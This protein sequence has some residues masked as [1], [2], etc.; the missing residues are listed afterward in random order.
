M[1]MIKARPTADWARDR[2]AEVDVELKELKAAAKAESDRFAETVNAQVTTSKE[3][4]R[5][6][7]AHQQ[8][9]ERSWWDRLFDMIRDW[10]KQASANNEAWEKQRNAESRDAMIADFNVL[11]QMKE[12]QAKGNSEAVNSQF[13]KLSA[14]QKRLASQYFSGGISGIDFVAQSTIGRIGERRVTE[15]TK[16]LE[17]QAIRVWEWN[18]LG[19]LAKATN[20][21]FDPKGL[22]AKVK[23]AVAGWG[24][25]E[26]QV[27]AALGGARTAIERA[28][29]AKAYQHM[30]GVSMEADIKDDM[31]GREMQRAKALMEGK[32]SEA[33]AAAIR[34][35]VEG[36]GTDEAAIKNALRGKSKEELKEIKAE[37][38]RMYKVDLTVDL[39]DDMEDAELDNALALADGDLDKA[40]A[41][42]LSDA[43]DGP[44]TD[45]E[46]LKKVYER[47]REE[48][49]AK[50]KSE[51]LTPGELKQRIQDR[52]AKVK[53]QFN[54]K[55]GNLDA[56]MRDELTDWDWKA[57]YGLKGLS[58]L[59]KPV[60]DADLKIV[61]AMQSGDVAR[62]D[63]A[64]AAKEHAGVYTS[65]DEIENVVRNQ[66]KQAELDVGLDLAA[67]RARIEALA[68]S[69]D[70]TEDDKKKQ[71]AD[72]ETESKNRE[73][74]VSAKAKENLGKLSTAYGEATNGSQTFDQLVKDETSGYSKDE[75][76]DLIAAGGKLSDEEE[77]YYATAG[78]GT[79]EDKIKE[80][81]KGKSKDE[82]DK[83]RKA[84]ADKHPGHTLD[85]DLLGDLSGREDLDVGHTLQ[86][87]D[88]ETFARQLEEAKTPEDRKK[89]IAGMKKMLDDRQKFEQTGTIGQ[90]FALGADPMNSA[91]QLKEAV[92]K[93]EAYDKALDA[94]KAAH[95]DAKPEDLAND[96]A[97]T[98]AKANFDMNYSGALESQEQVREQIDAYADVAVQVG[99]AV[100]ALAITIATAGTAGPVMAALYGAL[101]GAMTTIA[102]K[103][104]LRGAAYSWEEAGVDVAVGAVDAAMSAATAGLSKGLA[105]A[106]K[107]ALEA[108]A[109]AAAKSGGERVSESAVK[110]WLKEAMKEAV[111]NAAQGIPSAFT[112]AILDDNTWKSGDPW[113][114]IASATGQGAAMGAG[115]G[116]AMKGAHDLGGA[117]WG[118]IKGRAKAEPRIEAHG[119]GA[120]KPEPHPNASEAHPGHTEP[121][122]QG[123]EPKPGRAPA[124]G[125]ARGR[126]REGRPRR[127]AARRARQGPDQGRDD[128]RG[129]GPGAEARGRRGSPQPIGRGQ[130]HRQHPRGRRAPPAGR[131]RGHHRAAGRLRCPAPGHAGDRPH[132]QSRVLREVARRG[133]VPGGRAAAQRCDRRV[134]AGPGGARRG[135]PRRRAQPQLGEGDAVTRVAGPGSLVVRGAQ[136]PHRG[137][138]G[139]DAR[140]RALAERRRQGRGLQRRGQ[141]GGADGQAGEGGDPLHHRERPREADLRL[142]PERGQALL[143]RAAG[144]RRQDR[145]PRV[146]DHQR[147]PPGLR[148]QV[149]PR[150]WRP[151]RRQVPWCSRDGR[152]RDHRTRGPDQPT[153]R[154]RGP[155]HRPAQPR[156]RARGA[157]RHD[158][159]ARRIGGHAQQGARAEER[160]G[161]DAGAEAPRRAEQGRRGQV[162]LDRRPGDPLRDARRP[163][164]ARSRACARTW[165]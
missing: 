122:A 54:A 89:L 88:P 17:E 69:G 126:D 82:I 50:A 125:E 45:E 33:N 105:A 87:G 83:I 137:P 131:G 10:G 102:L 138:Q 8:G 6:W 9:K 142:R 95:P 18:D 123:P 158:S 133:S 98:S 42:E 107:A 150:A 165:A 149:R 7:A 141:G 72:W 132:R 110:A 39:A 79:D 155:G 66:R 130:E 47:I 57:S 134:R 41:A 157:R 148:G 115:M 4:V 81:L 111:M 163:T 61:E 103:A 27:Y 96:A 160:R 68:R 153:G 34:E 14:D 78:A 70:I 74:K 73:E 22:A 40:D 91:E 63:A 92:D 77:L 46:K 152:A 15:V 164:C 65:D 144:A 24:T 129:P 35:A 84:Y 30:Y 101:A 100:T 113:G 20:P 161:G 5:D 156:R 29:M 67:K 114:H 76:R 94:F 140:A 145:A 159:R 128:P 124:R 143:H 135:Q 116:V 120:A 86:Y 118:K 99:A 146:Q 28:A 108:A 49:E 80:V 109:K 147:L 58:G 162:A 32:S 55:Y 37:Y 25:K 1:G 11:T 31:E 13:A 62:I 16:K 106:E 53:V 85:G 93:A 117:A 43:M 26:D 51:G 121:H 154:A 112:T 19:E 64:K 38:K 71:L 36:L 119:P 44:G 3:S 12:A 23:G 52:N 97:L 2:S 60:D 59:S 139:R 56:R 151:H 21:S 48:E 90:I 127:A 136:P 104:Q 75:I